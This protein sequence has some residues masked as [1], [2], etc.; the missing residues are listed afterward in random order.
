MRV[1]IAAYAARANEPKGPAVVV[2]PDVRGLF[3]FYE[4]LALRLAELLVPGGIL[5]TWSDSTSLG[6]EANQIL[7]NT[8]RRAFDYRG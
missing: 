7:I 3:R 4:E 6:D 5:V 2:M 1:I 8:G